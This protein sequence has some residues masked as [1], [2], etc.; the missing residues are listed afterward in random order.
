MMIRGNDSESLQALNEDESGDDCEEEEDGDSDADADDGTDLSGDCEDEEEED[1]EEDDIEGGA[2]DDDDDDDHEGRDDEASSAS[3]SSVSAAVVPTKRR[4]LTN[5]KSNRG[6]G[7]TNSENINDINLGNK[8]KKKLQRNRTSFTQAQIEALEKEFESTHYPDGCSREK[9][10]QRIALPEARIQVWFS[11]RRAKFRREDKL[12]SIGESQASETPETGGSPLKRR[13]LAPSATTSPPSRSTMPSK[14]LKSSSAA[15]AAAASSPLAVTKGASSSNVG[16]GYQ[17]SATL[18]DN[19]NTYLAASDL[20]QRVQGQ[21]TANEGATSYNQQSQ[22][23]FPR[24]GYEEHAQAYDQHSIAT[25]TDAVATITAPNTSN[26]YHQ[27]QANNQRTN[28]NSASQ[29]TPS[30]LSYYQQYPSASDQYYNH[31]QQQQQ[32][33]H[34]SQV[35]MDNSYNYMFGANSLPSGLQQQQQ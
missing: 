30:N 15:A 34:Q 7:K 24:G 22:Q 9:L 28:Y 5:E 16:L 4:K 10:A 11:N 21:Q 32:Q 27:I 12:R 31:H 26:A 19:N 2:D 14:R 3:K 29:V 33:Q 8:K 23:N 25:T 18:L 13:Q 17:A 20:S 6:I 35:T 1:T